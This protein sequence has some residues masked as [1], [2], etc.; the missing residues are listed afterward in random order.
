MDTGHTN[1]AKPSRGKC[2]SRSI[3]VLEG[4][5]SIGCG[6]QQPLTSN[7]ASL[8]T[9]TPSATLLSPLNCRPRHVAGI[10][11][12][13]STLALAGGS[14]RELPCGNN[15]ALQPGKLFANRIRTRIVR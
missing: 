13:H 10:K 14:F 3:A 5:M 8:S 15:R 9:T 11:S 1:S 12:R 7:E 4:E 2:V 6:E